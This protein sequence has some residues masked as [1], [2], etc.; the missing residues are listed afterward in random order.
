MGWTPRKPMITKM[1]EIV[2][3]IVGEKVI[4]VKLKTDGYT[5]V[6]EPMAVE[7]TPAARNRINCGAT[8]RIFVSTKLF[9]TVFR[10]EPFI[11][12]MA[13]MGDTQQIMFRIRTDGKM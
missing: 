1:P 13:P 12:I 3:N 8:E 2:A 7:K 6:R 10:G 4:P 11:K 5:L 9:N